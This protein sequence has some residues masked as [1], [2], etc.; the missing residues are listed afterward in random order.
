MFCPFLSSTPVPVII[1]RE[2]GGILNQWEYFNQRANELER[3]NYKTPGVNVADPDGS[4]WKKR[5]EIDNAQLQTAAEL[6][7]LR[8]DY[9]QY[10]IEQAKNDRFNRV[11]NFAMML[12]AIVSMIIALVK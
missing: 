12:I 6:Q 5:R 7:K 3:Y 1:G 2:G 4:V 9:V 8:D 10:K 11:Y